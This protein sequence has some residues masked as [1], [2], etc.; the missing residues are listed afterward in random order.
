MKIGPT[1]R[2]TVQADIVGNVE[3]LLSMYRPKGPYTDLTKGKHCSNR[4][5]SR[6]VV[7]GRME[8]DGAEKRK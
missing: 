6:R 4:G 8:A 5:R 7:A 1:G 2:L 3:R